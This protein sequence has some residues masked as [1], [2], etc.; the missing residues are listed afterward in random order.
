MIEKFNIAEA[1]IDDGERWVRER[2]K[3]YDRAMYRWAQSQPEGNTDI[4]RATFRLLYPK[5]EIY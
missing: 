5:D 2:D 3:A 4:N 1:G